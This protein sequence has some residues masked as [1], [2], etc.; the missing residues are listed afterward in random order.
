VQIKYLNIF[1]AAVQFQTNDVML[2]HTSLL[3]VMY[4]NLAVKSMLHNLLYLSA[5]DKLISYAR[6]YLSLCDSQQVP[7]T[8]SELQ[9][10]AM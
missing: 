4:F 5:S 10:N 8:W 7:V 1:R 3:T 9:C 6:R 2:I